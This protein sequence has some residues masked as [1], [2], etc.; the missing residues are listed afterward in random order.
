MKRCLMVLFVIVLCR[1]EMVTGQDWPMFRGPDHNGIAAGKKYVS[2]WSSS[3]NVKWKIKLDVPGNGSPIVSNGRVFFVDAT[4]K[5]K[6]RRLHCYDRTNGKKLWVKTVNFKQVM[7]TH[8]TNPHGATTPAADGKHVVV[9]HSSAGLY[10]YDFSGKK[11]WARDLGKFQH[12]W[13]YGGSPVIY[14]DRVILNCSPGNHNFVTALDLK[15]GKTLW[16]TTEPRDGTGSR[17]ADGAFWGSWTTPAVVKVGDKSQ[18]I[19][20]MPTRVNGLDL[21]SGKIIWSCDGTR[22]PK[23]DLAYSSPMIGSGFCL[24]TGGFNGPSMSFK[25]GGTGN[26][27]KSN[28]LWRVEKSP[29][30]VGSGIIVG[31]YAYRP[32]AGPGT[33]ECIEVET[34]KIKWRQ[35]AGGNIWAS[36]ILADNKLFAIN[37]RGTTLV[38]KPNPEKFESVAENSLQETC[39]ATPAF[40]DGEIFIRTFKHLYCIGKSTK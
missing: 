38:F 10:C 14:K 33:I 22:G 5:G 37:Q 17:R 23:G 40:S 29:Q 35:R 15:S 31:K 4:E 26:I 7:P 11:L 16:E 36:I 18:V 32:N 2:D 20:A 24:S 25:L 30:S 21:E 13:G 28:R 9:W 3:K 12:I 19:C 39:N 8:K 6:N 34:G 27:T 1:S